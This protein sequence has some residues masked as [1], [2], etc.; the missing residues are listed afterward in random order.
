[1][2]CNTLEDALSS[3]LILQA[4]DIE[5]V[6]QLLVNGADINYQSVEGWCLLFELISMNAYKEIESLRQHRFYIDIKDSKGRSALFWAIHYKH[7]AVIEVL[8]TMG[9]NLHEN[10]SNGLPSLHYAIHQNIPEIVCLLLD[11]GAD[12]ES[13][14]PYHNTA[15]NY[16]MLYE[17]DIMIDLLISRGAVVPT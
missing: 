6:K 13:T 11:T 5:T 16:A 3:E 2:S 8:L 15:L 10:V 17:N 7:K 12:I 14:D 9:I 1:M 4:K